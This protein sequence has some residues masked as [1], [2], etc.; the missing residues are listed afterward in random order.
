ML[1]G[2]KC[3][4]RV[5][6]LKEE[7]SRP[8]N[9]FFDRDQPFFRQSYNFDRGSASGLDPTFVFGLRKSFFL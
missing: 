1:N 3:R 8:T 4:I 9:S 6:M 2:A 7:S 5:K